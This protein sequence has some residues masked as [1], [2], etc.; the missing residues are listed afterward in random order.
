MNSVSESVKL[1]ILTTSHRIDHVLAC[2]LQRWIE[3]VPSLSVLIIDMK[4]L[5]RKLYVWREVEFT[6]EWS[7]ESAAQSLLGSCFIVVIQIELLARRR[8]S[9]LPSQPW[10][11]LL[12]GCHDRRVVK[13]WPTEVKY[14][15]KLEITFTSYHSSSI[16]HNNDK[17]VAYRRAL[18]CVH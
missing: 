1:T 15:V 18:Q 4:C 16:T 6:C 8:C 5:K 12:K 13:E 10:E 2:L 7:C 9:D 14:I 3:S 11:L 17:E